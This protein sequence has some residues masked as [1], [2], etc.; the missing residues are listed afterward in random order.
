VTALLLIFA[1]LLVLLV[2]AAPLRAGASADE[3]M[4]SEL[5]RADLEARKEARYREIRDAELDR[6]TGKISV[7]DWRTLDARLRADAAG[8]LEQI[9]RIDAEQ[10]ADST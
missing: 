2:L 3:G 7:E 10:P 4:G 9:D 1:T 5:R 8:L 6:E